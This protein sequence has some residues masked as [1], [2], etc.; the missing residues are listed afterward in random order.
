MY[1]E[2]KGEK[3]AYKELIALQKAN[4]AL[5]YGSFEVL[6]RRRDR[7]TYRRKWK[8][9]VFIIDCNLG[10]NKQKAYVSKDGY[11]LAYA[12]EANAAAILRPYEARIWVKERMDYDEL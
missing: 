12:S 8:N 2:K 7:F 1:A 5:V 4:K 3:E 10:K 9:Q 11:K 6:D